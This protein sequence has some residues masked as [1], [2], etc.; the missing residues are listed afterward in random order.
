L[1]V[2][3]AHVYL[4]YPFVLSYSPL[5]AMSCAA[6]LVLSD[7][8]PAREIA[9]AGKHA[10]FVDFHS[11]ADIAAAVIRLLRDPEQAGRLGWAAREHVIGRYDLERV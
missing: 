10:L 5:E 6:P 3:R 4:T 7:T 2:S 1:T 8:A 11:P 9:E